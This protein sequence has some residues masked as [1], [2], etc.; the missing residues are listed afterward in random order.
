MEKARFV[1]VVDLARQ[2]RA[3][4]F[5]WWNPCTSGLVARQMGE[6]EEESFA[7]GPAL[8]PLMF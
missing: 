6:L 2:S 1:H 3:I 7:A 5:A 4:V 8:S